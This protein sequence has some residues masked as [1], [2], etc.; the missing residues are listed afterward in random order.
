MLNLTS[1]I[2]ASRIQEWHSDVCHHV[3]LLV[4]LF[5]VIKWFLKM[6]NRSILL[7]GYF[8]VRAH[9]IEPQKGSLL[10]SYPE[11]SALL[12]PGLNTWLISKDDVKHTTQ[13]WGWAGSLITDANTHIPVQ[14]HMGGESA[15]T[16]SHVEK[17][18]KPDQIPRGKRCQCPRGR[19][20]G[21]VPAT[22]DL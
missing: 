12:C 21:P 20:T 3:R 18:R 10:K 19:M 16:E 9:S 17:A 5:P 14:Q 7:Q 13:C 8:E 1:P 2:L 6:G 22:E 15:D 11:S 4:F